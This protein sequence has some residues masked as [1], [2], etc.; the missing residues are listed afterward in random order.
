MINEKHKPVLVNEVLQY[1]DPQPGKTYLDVTFGSGGHT[2]AILDKEPTCKVIAMDWDEVTL[3]RFGQDLLPLYGDRLKLIWGNFALLYRVLK[4]EGIHKVDG[5][6][7]DFGTSQVQI[8]ERPGLSLFKDAGLDMRMSP[9]HQHE[10]AEDVI[11]KVDEKILADIFFTFGEERYSRRISRAIVEQRAKKKIKTTKELVAIID[12]VV[13][14][15]KHN[16]HKATRVFQALRIYVNRELHNIRSFLPAALRAL[17]PDGRIVCISFHSLEDRIV[18]Q[19]F[20]E[21]H[22][23]GVLEVLT[24]KVVRPTFEEVAENSSSRS[25]RLRAARLI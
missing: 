7:A 16:I 14:T 23:L 10:T 18:K 9:P 25:S 4:R 21:Q 12:A 15:T 19:Y 17:N 20:K 11:N 5:I 22:D 24:P 13:P 6:L 8:S 2:Q 1:L 3:N